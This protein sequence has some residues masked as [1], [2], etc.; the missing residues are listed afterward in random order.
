MAHTTK[1]KDYEKYY[2]CKKTREYKNGIF[3]S[4]NKGKKNLF[5]AKLIKEA[6]IYIHCFLGNG[7]RTGATDFSNEHCV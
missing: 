6:Q 7:S 2:I 4:K 5:S 1:K 3:K